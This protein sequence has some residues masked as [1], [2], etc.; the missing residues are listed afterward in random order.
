MEST[1]LSVSVPL[2]P[3]SLT[4]VGVLLNFLFGI[5]VIFA[6]LSPFALYCWYIK[7]GGKNLLFFPGAISLLVVSLFILAAIGAI[8]DDFLAIIFSLYVFFAPVVSYVIYE[9]AGGKR[10]WLRF[11]VLLPFAAIIFKGLIGMTCGCVSE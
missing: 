11:L 9:R 3:S 8:G 6:V 1:D 4:L 5:V 7:R 2:M 10:K